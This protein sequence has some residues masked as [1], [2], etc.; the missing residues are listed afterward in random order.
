MWAG[1]L[2]LGGRNHL[3]T[4]CA[5]GWI[6][7][8]GTA[9]RKREQEV[10]GE[11]DKISNR[12]VAGPRHV[13]HVVRRCRS[14]PETAPERKRK[15]RGGCWRGA[16]A[17]PS[18]PTCAHLHLPFLPPFVPQSWLGRNG[19]GKWD[20]DMSLWKSHEPTSP[21]L[22]NPN[23]SVLKEDEGYVIK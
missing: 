19:V 11:D 20:G 8:G 6:L 21:H 23:E 3:L 1:Y 10:T 17:G 16:G 4:I 7:A 18:L 15:G 13:S 14:V 9:A 2:P 12:C 5:R 22:F